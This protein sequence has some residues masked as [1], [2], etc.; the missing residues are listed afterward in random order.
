MAVAYHAFERLGGLFGEWE[1]W[2]LAARGY[3]LIL[4]VIIGGSVLL[5][6][7]VQAAREERDVEILPA[8]EVVWDGERHEGGGEG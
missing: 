5:H 3:W 1:K 8:Q 7:L 2:S 6:L 4:S